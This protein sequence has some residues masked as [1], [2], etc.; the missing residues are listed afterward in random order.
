MIP[1]PFPLMPPSLPHHSLGLQAPVHHNG[2]V[3]FF[4]GQ[5]MQHASN[6]GLPVFAGGFRS[7]VQPGVGLFGNLAEKI[8]Q[9]AHSQ[10][11]LLKA[12]TAEAVA[13][14]N[15]GECNVCTNL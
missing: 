3:Y 7:R 15:G 4:K 1:S 10:S 9:V 8:K 5:F 14:Y 6:N 12:A 11:F 13:E 2:I